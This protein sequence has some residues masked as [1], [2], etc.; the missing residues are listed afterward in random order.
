MAASDY[1]LCRYV[2][3]R[4]R[5]WGF[6]TNEHQT[7]YG[8]LFDCQY[9]Y[10]LVPLAA[11]T[12]EGIRGLLIFM[13]IY[14]VTVIGIFA[15]ILQMRIRNGMVEQIS[16]LSGLSKNNKNLAILLTMFMLSVAGIPPFIGFFGKWF[17]F[18]PAVEAGLTWLV[19]L[20]L[21]ASVIGAFYYLRVIKTMWFDEPENEFVTAPRELRV[22]ATLSGLLVLPVLLLPF[23][24]VSVQSWISQ[25][26]NGL[27]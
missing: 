8:I 20:A 9:G 24:A 23:V 10:A 14:V 3:V 15:C 22:M 13:S 16:D 7:P 25:A 27:F 11:G 4:R 17:A 26:A 19:V 5:D 21:V 12:P 18:A 6:D 2:Y 1:S